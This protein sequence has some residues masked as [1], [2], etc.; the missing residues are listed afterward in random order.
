MSD[1]PVLSEEQVEKIRNSKKAQE[2]LLA[3]KE[4]YVGF[5]DRTKKAWM[6]PMDHNHLRITR[7]IK[8]LRLLVDDEGTAA[9]DFRKEVRT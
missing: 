1:T 3:G 9:D 6:I 8:S 2:S 4:K 7:V 5:L